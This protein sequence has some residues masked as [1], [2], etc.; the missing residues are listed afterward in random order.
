M[1][2][3]VCRKRHKS[4]QKASKR[5]D[6]ERKGP[7]RDAKG[8]VERKSG[9]SVGAPSLSRNWG[10]QAHP[11]FARECGLNLLRIPSRGA[12]PQWRHLGG[13]EGPTLGAGLIRPCWSRGARRVIGSGDRSSCSSLTA[14]CDHPPHNHSV[15]HLLLIRS[16]CVDTVLTIC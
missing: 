8:Q 1:A 4:V 7:K 14:G 2:F 11:I 16:H 6:F 13:G 12:P 5:A 10:G 9:G 15:S 3:G